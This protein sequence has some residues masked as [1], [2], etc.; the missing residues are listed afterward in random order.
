ML[1]DRAE[2]RPRTRLAPGAMWRR[3]RGSGW[4]LFAI[5]A[6]LAGLA[7][8]P[9]TTYAR[10]AAARGP[11]S[12]TVRQRHGTAS[13]ARPVA[14][15]GFGGGSGGTGARIADASDHGHVLTL[16]NA[17]LTRAGKYGSAA[18]FTGHDSFATSPATRNLDLTSRMTLEAWVRPSKLAPGHATLIA[19]TRASGGFPYGLSLTDGRPYAYGWIAGR[20]VKSR[21]GVRLP[22]NR[23][24]FVAATYDGSTLRLYIGSQVEAKVAA[25]GTFRK[26]SGPLQIGG[27]QVQGEFFSGAIDDVRIFSEAR[28][29]K[30]LARDRQT[31]VAGGILRGP[32]STTSGPGAT[33]PGGGASGAPSGGPSGIAPVGRGASAGLGLPAPTGPAVYVSQSTAGSDDGSSCANAHS[34]DW[35]NTSGNWGTGAGQI[36]PGDVVHLCGTISSD[37]TVQGSGSA[38]SPITIYFEPGAALSQPACAGACLSMSNRSYVTINGGGTGVIQNTANGTG[39]ADSVGDTAIVADPC[40]N[41]TIEYVTIQDIYVRTSQADTGTGASGSG[42]MSVSGSNLT[43]AD[44]TM[45]Y[46][47]WC[48]Y[49]DEN[50]HTTD[51]NLRFSGN[52]IS[53]TDHGIALGFYNDAGGAGLGPFYFNDN[54]VHDYT[55]WDSGAA[56]TYHHDGFHCF[57]AGSG[58]PDIGGGLYIYNNVWGGNVGPQNDTAQIFLEGTASGT[59]CATPSTPIY[60][61]NNVE[62]ASQ[63][64][65][66]DDAYWTL[67]SGAI[68]AYNNTLLGNGSDACFDFNDQT[69]PAATIE[70]TLISGCRMEI[71]NGSVGLPY[72][73]MGP[74]YN[75]YAAS[76]G[77]AFLCNNTVYAFSQFSKWQSCIGGD[78]HSRTTANAQVNSDGT[79]KPVSPAI[80]AG[81]NLT[82]LCTGALAPLCS[83]IYGVPR[84]VTGPWNAGAF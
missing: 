41:C 76:G 64:G 55:A 51:S 49:V 52:D 47:H 7:G 83:D 17:M 77:N 10:H 18:R 62:Q 39:L 2:G 72:G 81:A 4:L 84:P 58:V 65:S 67:A 69:T 13:P 34:A 75:L 31:P 59:P 19:K 32:L 70:N 46:A 37:L 11:H 78:S 26:S 14:A 73:G 25:K 45:D 60:L 3:P 40:T 79:L 57:A 27:D 30:Q 5:L 20:L 6:A 74:D 24:S 22:K 53:N 16:V 63:I 33:A 1:V 42:C 56:D 15:W 8:G 80:G 50:R 54:Y 68:H 38:G 61:F 35:L 28:S 82:S 48:V 44:N 36:G 29:P 71:G 66:P 21:A 12:G 9:A 43:V 23:W